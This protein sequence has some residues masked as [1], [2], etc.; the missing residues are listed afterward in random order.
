MAT[1][2]GHNDEFAL[3]RGNPLPRLAAAMRSLLR[4]EMASFPL[5]RPA[6]TMRSLLRA[7]MASFARGNGLFSATEAGSA[8]LSRT[9]RFQSLF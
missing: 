6:A 2:V 7:E 1:E 3:A 5:P 9:T 8:R 4:A